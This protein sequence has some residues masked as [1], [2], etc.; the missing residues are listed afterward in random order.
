MKTVFGLIATLALFGISTALAADREEIEA[1][2]QEKLE[3]VIEELELTDEQVAAMRPIL[4][5][6]FERQAAVLEEHGV[7]LEDRSREDRLSRRERRALRSDLKDEREE[8][9]EALSEVLN[10]EQLEAYRDM[11]EERQDEMRSRLKNRRNN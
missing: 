4:E 10:D 8:T 6:S 9:M 5:A 11:A 2:A 1:K 7:S 3:Q